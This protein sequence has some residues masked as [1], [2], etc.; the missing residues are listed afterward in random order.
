[1]L[2]GAVEKARQRRV[3]LGLVE[4]E[5]VVA[6]VGLDLDEADIG[7]DRVERMDD[8]AAFRVGKSQSEVKE[9][10]QKRTC[11]PWKAPASKPPW[12]AARSK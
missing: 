7:R 4:Q 3:E 5:G 1:M 12:S 11:V 9:T 6:L 2:G 8:G 10:T